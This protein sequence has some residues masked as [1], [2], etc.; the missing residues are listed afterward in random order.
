MQDIT[1]QLTDALRE[2]IAIVGDEES[3][4][5]PQKHMERLREVSE[6]ISALSAQLPTGIDGRLRHYLDR[7]SFDKALAFLEGAAPSAPNEK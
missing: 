5:E 6:K 1:T 3:R 2:R 7:C 4:R